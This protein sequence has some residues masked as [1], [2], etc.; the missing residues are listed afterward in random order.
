MAVRN[1]NVSEAGPAI[2]QVSD[3]ECMTITA[4]DPITFKKSIYLILIIHLLLFREAH[5]IKNERQITLVKTP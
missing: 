1:L 3:M 2:F 4:K 5:A